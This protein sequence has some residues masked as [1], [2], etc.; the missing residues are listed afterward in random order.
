M[1]WFRICACLI[2]LFVAGCE[3][4]PEISRY[5]VPKSPPP[6][7]NAQ[8]VTETAIPTEPND[9]LLGAIIPK[10]ARTWFFKLVGPKDILAEHAGPFLQF[11]K[12]VRF[13]DD[14]PKWEL[15]EGWR[16]TAGAEMRFATIK[17]DAAGQTLEMS[18][19]PLPTG[20]GEFND[21]LL[22]NINRWRGQMNVPPISK[23]DLSD[24]TVS[25]EVDGIPST[26]VNIEGNSTDSGM[27]G[28]SKRPAPV[29]APN[30]PARVDPSL[31]FT[32][33]A[34][35]E[36]TQKPAGPMRL[37]EFEARDGAQRVV[38][39]ISTAGGDRLANINRWRGQVQ[40]EP[41][42][43]GQ[44]KQSL[45]DIEIGKL[46]GDYVEIVGGE[47]SQPRQTILGVIVESGGQQWFFKLQG[48]SELAAKEK[49]RFEEFVK[50]LTFK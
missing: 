1:P 29:T 32:F 35:T 39:S 2:L 10:G 8:T 17:F 3:K 25:I 37:A 22:A 41:L 48:D 42:D 12:S 50:S 47:K 11:V 31:P 23:N 5:T 18:V 46:R 49:P 6:P 20:D 13:S 15:P 34:P 26:L 7:G 21:Y 24:K 40:L 45:R 19:I 33:S 27:P 44:L 36:W 14:K 16:E 9:R 38:V 30:G 4:T 43:P 28:P